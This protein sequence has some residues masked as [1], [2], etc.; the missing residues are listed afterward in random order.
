MKGELIFAER[1][2]KLCKYLIKQL[3]SPNP[4]ERPIVIELFNSPWVK[5][6]QSALHILDRDTHEPIKQYKAMQPSNNQ[7]HDFFNEDKEI[8]EECNISADSVEIEQS[9]NTFES[10]LK[11]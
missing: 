3:L 10:K 7:I 8:E 2:S 6:M 9:N 1:V 4:E 11:C 5:K